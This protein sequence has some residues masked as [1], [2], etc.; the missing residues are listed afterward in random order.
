[1]N[2]AIVLLALLGIACGALNASSQDADYRIAYYLTG[3]GTNPPGRSTD[4]SW[5][6]QLSPLIG[7]YT[8]DDPRVAEEHIRMAVA[9]GVNA[10]AIPSSRPAAKWGWEVFFERGLLQAI[11]LSSMRFCMMFNNEPWWDNPHLGGITW[12]DLTRETV[13]YFAQ[14][15]FPHEQYL[16]VGGRPVLILYHAFIFRDRFGLSSLEKGLRSVSCVNTRWKD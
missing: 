1:M 3:W 13:Q 14:E 9:H 12:Q 7:A 11:N 4:N 8:S 5:Y 16:C 2:K 10:F 15:Y 6:P